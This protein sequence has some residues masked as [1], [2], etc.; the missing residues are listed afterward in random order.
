M[1]EVP[2]RDTEMDSVESDSTHEEES[3]A[4][5]TKVTIELSLLQNYLNNFILYVMHYFHVAKGSSR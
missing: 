1:A 5:S 4:Y 2:Y 3:V